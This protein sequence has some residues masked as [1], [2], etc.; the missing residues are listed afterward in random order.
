MTDEEIWEKAAI[1][2]DSQY[3]EENAPSQWT[4]AFHQKF[5]EL[6]AENSQEIEQSH[7]KSTYS[8]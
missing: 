7:G 5:G 2:A 4:K 6:L 8:T 3:D 1:Y